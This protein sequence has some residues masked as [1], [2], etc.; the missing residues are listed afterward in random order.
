MN[1]FAKAVLPQDAIP[2]NP[3]AA[4]LR[5]RSASKMTRDEWRIVGEALLAGRRAYKSDKLFGQWCRASGFGDIEQR[6]RTD[7]MWL[8]VNWSTIQS[9]D[10]LSFAHP[11]RIR[12][13]YRA[14][15]AHTEVLLRWRDLLPA[16]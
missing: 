10:L 16:A 15:V 13:A 2:Q 4:W 3:A 9:L 14:K 6:G 7:A 12:A 1:A 5:T 11:S 8:A